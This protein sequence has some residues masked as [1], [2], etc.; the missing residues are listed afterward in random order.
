MM[1]HEL[2]TPLA[3]IQLSHDMMTQYGNRA[4]E[5]EK[6]Q[7]LDN[8]ETQVYHLTEMIKDVMTISRSAG[9]REEFAPEQVD[10]VDYCR[11]IVEEYQ[12]HYYKTH[13][14]QFEC[15]NKFIKATVDKKLLRQALTNLLSNAVKYSPQGGVIQVMLYTEGEEAILKITDHGIGINE[16]DQ[17]RLFEPFHRG[18]NVDTIPGTGL[19]LAIVKQAV[20]AHE[21]TVEVNSVINGGS[22][23]ILRLPIIYAN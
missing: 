1:S 22:T 14:I 3:L 17:K 12:S 13:R 7:Y 10:L 21:G 19:G 11:A 9:I 5:E 16:E 20:T 6:Q 23:F 15:R 8:I 18:V 2:R 4:T